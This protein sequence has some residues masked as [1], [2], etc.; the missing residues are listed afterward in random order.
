MRTSR[1]RPTTAV[2]FSVSAGLT[3]SSGKFITLFT[4]PSPSSTISVTLTA[5]VSKTN[6]A[7]DTK[8]TA[9][10][11]S[12]PLPNL[13]IKVGDIAF[14][15]SEPK[16]GQN[17]MVTAKVGN[18]GDGSANDVIVR[19]LDGQTQIGLDQTITTLAKGGL[20]TVQVS[21]TPQT[22]G[23]HTIK[24]VVDPDGTI[25]E[26]DKSDNSAEASVDVLAAPPPSNN[27][28]GT[29]ST[30]GG[31]GF[32]VGGIPWWVIL[33]VVFLIVGILATAVVYKKRKKKEPQAQWIQYGGAPVRA[34][35]TP[36]PPP[37]LP[38]APEP[39]A[40]PQ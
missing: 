40:Q 36:Q 15:V 21:W 6:Y 13:Q 27:N 14:S 16:K 26:T 29:G 33:V 10:T 24:V 7:T 17:L 3:D 9:I 34:P 23:K 5:T 1:Y 22:E 4:A 32:T 37:Q 8:Q 35:P 28:Q 20:V 31:F 30:T 39:P 19:F 38:P 18:V 25:P 11:V 12:P 2:E